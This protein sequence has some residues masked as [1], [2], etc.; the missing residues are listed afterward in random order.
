MSTAACVIFASKCRDELMT[1]EA[2][3]VFQ[4]FYATEVWKKNPFFT[5]AVMA[6]NNRGTR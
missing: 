2:R 4:P 6:L 3:D 5:L 1:T